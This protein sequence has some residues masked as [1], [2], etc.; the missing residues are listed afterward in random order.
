MKKDYNDKFNL[1]QENGVNEYWLANPE[2]KAIQIFA[3]ENEEYQEYETFEDKDDT[4]TSKL[5]PEMK[6]PMTSVLSINISL[7]YKGSGF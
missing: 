1:Y 4:I 3:L 2:M 5:S 6:F 7:I